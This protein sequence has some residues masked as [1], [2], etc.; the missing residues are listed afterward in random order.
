MKIGIVQT[1]PVTG[2]IQNNLIDHLK[3]VERAVELEA[4]ALFFPE[5][6]ITG[7]EPKL[8]EELAT[9]VSDSLFDPFQKL[10]NDHSLTIGIGMPTVHSYGIR[11]SM[12]L[13]QAFT[14]RSA[15]SKQLLHKDELAYFCS[16]NEQVLLKSTEQN[17]AIGICYETLQE[18][19][20]INAQRSGA[21]IYIASVAKSQAGVDKAYRHFPKMAKELNMPILMCN[22]VG[23]CDNFISAGK[24]AAWDS[25]GELIGQ[26]S[27]VNTG[28]LVYDTKL[29]TLNISQ[30]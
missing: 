10:A 26:L 2:D 15:Y 25:K 9:K 27:Q 20:L 16:G 17:I 7:Y 8:S 22:S 13:F 3:M 28:I 4:D 12:L 19:H 21:D 14:E 1:R 6:S 11:I 30:W 23:Y 18:Q 29:N 5:L 24:S